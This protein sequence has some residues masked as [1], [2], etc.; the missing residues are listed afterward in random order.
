MRK[1]WAVLCPLRPL[2]FAIPQTATASLL[3]DELSWVQRQVSEL[4]GR[5]ARQPTDW[6]SA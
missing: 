2:A 4:S 3:P 6:S 1:W 5:L